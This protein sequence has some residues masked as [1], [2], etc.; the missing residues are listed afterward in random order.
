MANVLAA[1]DYLAAPAK[2]PPQPVCVAFGDDLF[3]KQHVLHA[4]REAVLGTNEGEFSCTAFA[5]EDAEPRSVFDELSTVALF[6]G[7]QRLV[8]VEDADSFVS[9]NRARLEDYAQ[10]PARRNVLLLE[11]TTWPSTTRL[12]KSVAQTGLQIKCSAPEKAADVARWIG[13]WAKEKHGITFAPQAKELLLEIIGP[14]LGLLDQEMAKLALLADRGKGPPM[15]S[16]EL[17][18]ENVGGWRAKTAWVMLDLAASGNAPAALTEL[19]RLVSSGEQPVGLLGQISSSLR[20]YAAAA[21]ILQAAEARH[22]KIPLVSAL[23]QAGFK[24]WPEAR[25][26]AESQMQQLGRARVNKLLRWLLETDL[27]LKGASSATPRFVLEQ[28]IARMAKQAGA[29][30][31]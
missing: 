16:A 10:K 9:K 25:Q 5:G 17:V 20:R 28:L 22:S 14:E 26:K 19:D 24:T 13:N 21:R 31:R 1:L 27:A 4:L 3:L 12:Y 29:A 11:V 30:P 8:L 6:G 23:E 18:R 15:I 7:G 2:Y